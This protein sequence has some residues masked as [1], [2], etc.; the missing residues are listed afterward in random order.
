MTRTDRR[1]QLR[2]A[3]LA[4]GVL[5][6]LLGLP[7]ALRGYARWWETAMGWKCGTT[8]EIVLPPR[9]K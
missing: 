3:L 4:L 2:R 9:A 6:I 8:V 7:W 1:P 5:L